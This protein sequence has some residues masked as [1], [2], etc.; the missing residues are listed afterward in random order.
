MKLLV[1]MMVK[2]Q[3]LEF[4]YDIFNLF[5]PKPDVSYVLVIDYNNKLHV[6]DPE[7][8]S[9]IEAELAR[10][11][12]NITWKRLEEE[13]SDFNEVTIFHRNISHT[14]VCSLQFYL[15]KFCMCDIVCGEL[16]ADMIPRDHTDYSSEC[17]HGRDSRESSPDYGA[18]YPISPRDLSHLHKVIQRRLEDPIEELESAIAHR[19]KQAQL[20]MMVTH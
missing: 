11:E 7:P 18:N 13:T 5:K 3:L 2:Y 4:S 8:M 14:S 10:L 12:L 1:N 20:Q 16:K 15:L 17:D 9:K 19:Q 6:F